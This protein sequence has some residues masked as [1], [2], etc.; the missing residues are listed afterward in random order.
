MK[1]KKRTYND[2]NHIYGRIFLAI[3]II[4]I[5]MIPVTI[6]LVLK[7]SPDFGVIAT[8]MLSLIVFLAGGFVEV[9]TYSPM[10]GT[11]GTY[12]GFFT[13]N[14]VNLKVPCVVN[15]RELA[16]VTWFKRR[17]NCFYNFCSNKYN[18]YNTSYC[19][20]CCVFNP[21]DSCIRKPCIKTCI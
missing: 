10:L 11:A 2:L 20:W 14:L 13:G 1:E 4:I 17:R 9:I 15:T 19:D 5:V 3:A 18:C 21:I 16:G 7:V 8:C 12:L 6:A